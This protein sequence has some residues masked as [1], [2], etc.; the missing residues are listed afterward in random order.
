MRLGI[1]LGTTRT[2]I[3]AAVKGNYPI[4]SFHTEEGEVFDWYPSLIAVQKERI[5]FGLDAWNVQYDA[6]WEICHSLKRLF[7]EREPSSIVSIGSIQLPL[8]EWLQQFLAALR[9]DLS[10]RSNLELPPNEKLEAMVGVPA[11]ANSN[12][13]FLTLEAF[14]AAGFEVLGLQNEPSAAGIEYA[15]RFRQ[16]DLTRR[17]EFVV[18]YDFGGGTFDV[19]VIHMAKQD[20]EVIASEGISRLGGDDL[21]EALLELALAHPELAGSAMDWISRSRLLNLCREAKENI[22]PNSRKITIDLGQISVLG[23]ELMIGVQNFYEKCLPLVQQTIESTESVMRSCL[24]EEDGMPS[25]ACVYLVG[26]SCELPLLSRSLKEKF[27]KRVRRSP[28]PSAAT[29]IGLAITADQQSGY[30]LQDRFSRHFGVWRES[31]FGKEMVFDP[32]FSKETRL[33]LPGEKPLTVT[34]AYHPVH[35]IGHFRFIECGQLG[36]HSQPMGTIIYWDETLFPFDPRLAEKSGLTE[37]D[38]HRWAEGASH[39]VEEIYRCDSRG[40]VEVDIADKTTGLLR[41][42]KVRT[43]KA[44][45]SRK[46]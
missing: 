37:Q 16:S 39:Q 17:R 30:K 33:P 36:E 13:R 7:G 31:N 40:I 6:T 25:L 19:S 3:A 5:L 24:A 9:S 10:T 26:G 35:N 12:Q 18:V 46:K 34:R 21:D 14:R 38:V 41:S 44:K 15:H 29:A 42:L 28:Y 2:R 11:N 32:I 8:I 22:N 45:N 20:H 23:G 1:D 4:I 43:T 27:G